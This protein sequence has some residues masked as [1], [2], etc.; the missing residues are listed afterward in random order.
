MLITLS[1]VSTDEALAE[2]GA[3]ASG[4][5]RI[6]GPIT[7]DIA[8]SGRERFIEE[9]GVDLLQFYF[10]FR[11]A[12][13]QSVLRNLVAHVRIDFEVACSLRPLDN[14]K[15]IIEVV[16]P[17]GFG[18][19]P[20]PA[21][22]LSMRDVREALGAVEECIGI[23]LRPFRHSLFTAF[24]RNQSGLLFDVLRVIDHDVELT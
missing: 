20:T 18:L 7:V 8:I 14:D 3:W 1:N 16:F 13:V 9:Q 21:L 12:I 15:F 19:K 11:D 23:Q 17:D 2:S 24:E 10:D 22:P 5:S 4:G 6:S